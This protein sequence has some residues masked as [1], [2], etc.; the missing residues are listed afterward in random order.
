MRPVQLLLIALL[1]AGALYARR[2]RSRLADH[3]LFIAVGTLGTAMIL[4]PDRTIAVAHALGV[5]RGVDL[6]IYLCLFGLGFV[7][8][9]LY[10]H[11]RNL[12]HRLTE[13]ARSI[14]LAN[15]RPAPPRPLETGL[16]RGE[17]AADDTGAATDE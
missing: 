2:L 3:L 13:L 11:L 15:A 16:A 8:L 1:A 4:F 12:E 6:I 5:G 7:C 14:A 17:K 9:V 10:D